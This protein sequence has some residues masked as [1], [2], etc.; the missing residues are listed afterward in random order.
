MFLLEKKNTER[1][2]VKYF[3]SELENKYFYTQQAILRHHNP[4]QKQGLEKKTGIPFACVSLV[5]MR[6]QD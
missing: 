6:G 2:R 3:D 5:L 1:I 4:A